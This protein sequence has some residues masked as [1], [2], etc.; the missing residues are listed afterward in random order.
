VEELAKSIA[1][2]DYGNSKL[3]AIITGQ[4]LLSGM[5][6]R[7]DNVLPLNTESI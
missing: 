6:R 7:T 5:F 1:I 2:V 4:L 3:N